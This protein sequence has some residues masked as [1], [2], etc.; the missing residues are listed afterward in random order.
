MSDKAYKRTSGYHNYMNH[1]AYLPVI[2]FGVARM[3]TGRKYRVEEHGQYIG[4]I[5]PPARTKAEY[6]AA[7]I[8]GQAKNQKK[9]ARAKGAMP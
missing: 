3:A 8:A 4:A 1:R 7:A 5:K 9:Q 6:R 2:S